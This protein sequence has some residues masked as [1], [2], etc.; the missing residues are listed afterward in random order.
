MAR[1]KPEQHEEEEEEEEVQLLPG[2]QD[3]LQGGFTRQS[4]RA[5]A[6]QPNR[7]EMHPEKACYRHT[8]R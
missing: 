2:Q 3:M 6:L 7:R 1:L 5:V 4:L 8:G